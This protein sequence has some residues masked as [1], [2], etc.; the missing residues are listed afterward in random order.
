MSELDRTPAPPRRSV[1]LLEIGP[2]GKDAQELQSG[3]A[4][5]AEVA[6]HDP[7]PFG[8]CACLRVRPST[9]TRRRTRQASSDRSHLHPRPSVLRDTG[10][11]GE[12]RASKRPNERHRAPGGPGALSRLR[13]RRSPFDVAGSVSRSRRRA[14]SAMSRRAGGEAPA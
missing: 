13:P 11:K 7:V 3:V 4:E 10:F 5:E 6:F 1:D 14:R 9:C 12:T 8:P 2:E